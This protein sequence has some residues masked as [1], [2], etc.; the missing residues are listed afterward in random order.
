MA[1]REEEV[2]K[3]R[4]ELALKLDAIGRK[5][6]EQGEMLDCIASSRYAERDGPDLISDIEGLYPLLGEV[7]D[8]KG[9]E[10][11][12]FLGKNSQHESKKQTNRQYK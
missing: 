10:R 1:T 7:M 9:K 12:T 4:M 3:P 6:G 2:S 11:K 8:G 5:F